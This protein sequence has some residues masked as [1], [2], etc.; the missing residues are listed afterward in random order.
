MARIF[1]TRYSKLP[2]HAAP[3][4]P[5]PSKDQWQSVVYLHGRIDDI[6]DPDAKNGSVANFFNE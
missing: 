3:A 1:L 6:L 4:L 5:I 2:F